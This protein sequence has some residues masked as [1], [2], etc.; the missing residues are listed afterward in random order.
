MKTNPERSFRALR[1]TCLD[2]ALT[3]GV[4]HGD[5]GGSQRVRR[6]LDQLFADNMLKA[7]DQI[8]GKRRVLVFGE[9]ISKASYVAAFMARELGKA[10]TKTKSKKDTS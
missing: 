1:K 9:M 7:F 2:D 6:P 4:V 5:L 10:K 8:S 3:I